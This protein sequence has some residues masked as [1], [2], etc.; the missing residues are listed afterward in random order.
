[1]DAN[2]SVFGAVKKVTSRRKS[3]S[4][5]KAFQWKYTL[6]TVGVVFVVSGFI[7]LVLFDMLHQQA[8]ARAMAPMSVA[9]QDSFSMV[10]VAA[11]VFGLVISLALGIAVYVFTHRIAGPVYV[12]GRGLEALGKGRIPALRPLRKNDEFKD[13]HEQ[14]CATVQWIEHERATRVEHLTELHNLAQAGTAEGASTGPEACENLVR[15]IDV[16]RKEA[17]DACGEGQASRFAQSQDSSTSP[18]SSH[19][20]A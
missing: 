6:L 8:R 15:R 1:M 3:Y 4:V 20:V 19:A 13:V 2:D 18:V 16:L 5:N 11:C 9:V 12:I 17:L 14:L 7:T 10:V